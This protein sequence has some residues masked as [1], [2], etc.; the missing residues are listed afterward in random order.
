MAY[1]SKFIKPSLQN[2]SPPKIIPIFAIIILIK[3]KFLVQEKEYTLFCLPIAPTDY[4]YATI[5]REYIDR[6]LPYVKHNHSIF[7]YFSS[8]SMCFSIQFFKY[9]YFHFLSGISIKFVTA[10]ACNCSH[11]YTD[12]PVSSYVS[13]FGIF[14]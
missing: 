5:G 6:C 10:D 7:F 11:M 3:H 13:Y 2:L 8:A 1:N 9:F 14:A 4:E 12:W